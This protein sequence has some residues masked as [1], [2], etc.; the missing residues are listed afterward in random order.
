MNM[1]TFEQLTEKLTSEELELAYKDLVEWN[2]TGVLNLNSII[3]KIRE[4]Y[5]KE[6][7]V[8]YLVHGM[9]NVILNEIAKR[10]YGY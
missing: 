10:H 9:P 8:D 5:N 7:S 3:R 1:I 6:Y 4:K 2:K